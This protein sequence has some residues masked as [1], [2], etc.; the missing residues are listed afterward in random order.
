M[1]T[2][3]IEVEGL[4]KYFGSVRAVEGIDLVV[5][6]GEIFG[7]LGPNGS[8]KTTT[9]RLLLDFVRP[10]RGT[11]R[12]LDGSGAD[13]AVRARV[14]Y[15]PGEL[16]IDHGYTANTLIDFYG[17]LRG[18]VDRGWV[19]QLLG[20]FELDPGRRFGELSTGNRRKVGVVQAF[21]HRPELYLLDEPTS[22]LD[23]LL[24]QEFYAL[25]RE[26]VADGATVLL[27]SHV[28]PEVE[29]LAGR[30]GILRQGRLVTVAAVD[31]LRRQARQRIDLHLADGPGPVEL[32]PF[33][34][35]DEVVELSADDRTVHLVVEGSVD[36]VVK[37]AAAFEVDR[38]VTHEG[39]LEDAFLRFYQEDR[40]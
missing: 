20:R 19:E 21:M 15:L 23:P 8:G 24:Q 27:S 7:Y 10:T 17:A 6:P 39:D 29:A 34:T 22:G 2:A 18:G 14:G 16:R 25:V 33:R 36:R 40:P 35:L 30:V 3:P 4:T 13:P 32:T 37:A 38:V 11:A 5:E 26:V 1:T 31:V 28:L 9:V 12:L